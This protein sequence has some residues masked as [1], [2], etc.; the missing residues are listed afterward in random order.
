MTLAQAAEQIGCDRTT[1]FRQARTL[2]LGVQIGKVTVLTPGE[3]KKLAK[4][5]NPRPRK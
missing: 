4:V 3:V 2:G 5:I 1:V